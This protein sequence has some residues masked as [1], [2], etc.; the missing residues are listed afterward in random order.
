M[1]HVGFK[2][3]IDVKQPEG[4][5]VPVEILADAILVI[6]EGI[7]AM[8]A[9]RL[10]DRALVLLIQH[11]SPTP[12]G[13]HSKP[14]SAKEVRAVLAGIENLEREYLKPK[15]SAGVKR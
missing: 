7:K 15:A 3:K 14:I 4:G 1:P 11:A 13:M 12:K 6:A 9:G 2:T 5:N 10:N 8:R